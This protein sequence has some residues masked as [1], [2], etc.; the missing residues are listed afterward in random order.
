TTWQS[1]TGIQINISDT[2]SLKFVDYHWD[3][4]T[5]TSVTLDNSTY[6][7]SFFT[8]IGDGHHTLYITAFDNVG[9]EKSI[10]LTYITDDTPPL[11]VLVFP[12]NTTEQ[13]GATEISLDIQ[14]STGVYTYHWDDENNNTISINTLPVLPQSVGLHRLY[15]YALDEMG[16]SAFEYYEF[17]VPQPTQPTQSTQ[18]IEQ[19]LI[20]VILS[21]MII[22]S[23]AGGVF[24]F[25]RRRA[26][27]R[28]KELQTTFDDLDKTFKEEKE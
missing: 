28:Q 5:N 8:P 2:N 9:N 27:I 17:T 22:G 15:V 20:P 16:N 13:E 4:T 6:K 18:P 12:Q 14:G 3:E 1:G 19:I 23:A 11:I 24:V 25:L 26:S 10:A 7:L 21:L